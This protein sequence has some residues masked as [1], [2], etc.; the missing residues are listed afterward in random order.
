V[1]IV[2]VEDEIE[3]INNT[4]STSAK[5]S[6]NNA[7]I[8]VSHHNKNRQRRTYEFE[9]TFIVDNTKSFENYKTAKKH[10]IEY[11]INEDPN[12][13]ALLKSCHPDSPKSKIKKRKL[14]L[15][16]ELNKSMSLAMELNALGSVININAN[17]NYSMVYQRKV[18]LEILLEFT[19]SE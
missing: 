1:K 6:V 15:S 19:P 7:K 13:E 14:E 10:A 11:G 4:F 8:N 2:H 9:D 12:I 17:Y 3:D 18:S 5:N 16:S